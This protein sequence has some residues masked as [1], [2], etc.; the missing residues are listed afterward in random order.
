[1][2]IAILGASRGLGAALTQHIHTEQPDAT[3]L[4]VS[5]SADKLKAL[6]RSTDWAVTADLSQDSGQNETLKALREFKPSHVF[7]VAGGGPFGFY[8]T[9]EFKSHEWAWQT[10]FLAAARI[11][12]ALLSE[13]VFQADLQQFLAVGSAIAGHKP[14][15]KAASYAAA[16]HALRGLVTTVRAESELL[17]CG[18]K[19][20]VRIYEPGYLDTDLLPANAW[21]RQQGIVTSP[22]AEARKL[23]QYSQTSVK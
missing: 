5:R 18:Y 4:L 20:D 9:K 23:W 22:Q 17:D 7:Y 6:T 3:L 8:Q 12:H 14:D 21:P 10:C 15:P 11:L 1:M 19:V 13:N 16:K 2:R